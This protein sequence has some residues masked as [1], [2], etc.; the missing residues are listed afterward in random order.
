MCPK[1][2]I[3]YLIEM[4]QN[5]VSS[6]QHHH[7]AIVVAQ[8][9]EPECD[10]VSPQIWILRRSWNDHGQFIDSRSFRLLLG[11]GLAGWLGLKQMETILIHDCRWKL[12]CLI[13]PQRWHCVFSQTLCEYWLVNVLAFLIKL[14]EVRLFIPI[15]RPLTLFHVKP[16]NIDIAHVY[17]IYALPFTRTQ[18]GPTYYLFLSV[19]SLWL[20][21]SASTLTN[22]SKKHH[23]VRLKSRDFYSNRIRSDQQQNQSSTENVLRSYQ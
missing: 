7:I 16:H 21:C 1:T 3:S 6:T 4:L 23:L 20:V 19:C 9:E 8:A 15:F 11:H 18:T 10:Q 17:T 22:K 13:T 14:T 5:I 2:Q 12:N